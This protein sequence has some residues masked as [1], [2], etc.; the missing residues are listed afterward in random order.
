[1]NYAHKIDGEK[2]VRLKDYDPGEHG[3]LTREEAR[4]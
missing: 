1:M 2:K 3:G 4:I